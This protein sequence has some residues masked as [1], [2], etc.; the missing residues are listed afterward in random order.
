MKPQEMLRQ[1]SVMRDNLLVVHRHY[2]L[3]KAMDR[4]ARNVEIARL[5]V[6]RLRTGN[7]TVRLALSQAINLIG[8][9]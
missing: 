7:A 8:I 5:Q 3:W 2:P 6:K 4:N 1:L 9:L